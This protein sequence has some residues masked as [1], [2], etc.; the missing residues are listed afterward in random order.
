[1]RRRCSGALGGKDQVQSPGAA[2]GGVDRG[3]ESAACAEAMT[4]AREAGRL[5]GK[6]TN[7]LRW[8]RVPGLGGQRGDVLRDLSE[9]W[10]GGQ[11][12]TGFAAAI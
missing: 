8:G 10:R 2:S 7:E 1:M 4:R 6:M 3:D 11:P 9:K 12:R 5:G